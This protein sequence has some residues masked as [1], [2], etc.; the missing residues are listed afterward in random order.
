MGPCTG[1]PSRCRT[2]GPCPRTRSSGKGEG[3]HTAAGAPRSQTPLVARRCDLFYS[4]WS[5]RP[6]PSPAGLDRPATETTLLHLEDF[7]IPERLARFAVGQGMW[8]FI[9]KMAPHFRMFVERRRA[10]VDPHRPDPRAFGLGRPRNPPTAEE[11]ALLGLGPLAGLRRQLMAS[12]GLRVPAAAE[13]RPRGLRRVGSLLV[14]SCAAI[15]L[16]P[17][18]IVGGAAAGA[19]CAAALV[20][21]AVLRGGRRRNT[22]DRDS[23]TSSTPSAAPASPRGGASSMHHTQSMPALSVGSW[24]S[25]PSLLSREPSGNRR[26]NPPLA[27]N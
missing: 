14:A 16:A 12:K 4:M 24:S 1:S 5:C 9:R 26:N 2:P 27:L 7:R 21:T 23:S 13:E 15:A 19:T 20:G 17:P 11:L 25:G 3:A 8:G 6:V 18:G 22:A 10:R